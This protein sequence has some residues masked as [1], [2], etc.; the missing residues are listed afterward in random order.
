[1]P[2]RPQPT[3]DWFKRVCS[4]C[5][6]RYLFDDPW[7]PAPPGMGVLGFDALLTLLN[8][9][10]HPLT[11][12]PPCPYCGCYRPSAVTRWK[13]VRHL[14]LSVGLGGLAGLA[15]LLGWWDR[16]EAS[17]ALAGGVAVGLFLHA[18]VAFTDLNRCPEVNRRR[19]VALADR[20]LLVVVGEPDAAGT[21]KRPP[22]VDRR[23]WV[24]LSVGAAGL[25]LSAVPV[26]LK[27]AYGW[28]D[29]GGIQPRVVS[30]GDIVR[31][32]FPESI[33]AVEGNWAGTPVALLA[34]PTSVEPRPLSST[35][36]RS[37]WGN[38]IREDSK[39]RR[40][41]TDLWAEVTLPDDPTLAGRTV[42]L[43]VDMTVHYP[44]RTTDGF[45]NTTVVVGGTWP[46]RMAG[47]GESA[48][49]QWGY[50]LMLL[51]GVATGGYGLGLWWTAKR[52][53]R[54]PSRR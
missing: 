9:V 21:R 7:P 28:T 42:E 53:N 13:R 41:S 3:D 5:G 50:V 52:L 2:R 1:M 49:Y 40:E 44:K 27:A 54:L 25:L 6:A 29:H 48:V 38:T 32:H 15:C 36:N 11:D 45:E 35:A 8:C 33:R 34:D 31:V 17:W 30:P 12:E 39:N 16:T 26:T 37:T 4:T 46:V 23:A 19:P 22:S 14:A 20:G 47:R 43:R 18:V 24:W 10:T 51:G